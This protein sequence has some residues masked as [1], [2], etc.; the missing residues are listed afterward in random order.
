MY[1]ELETEGTIHF[2]Y[3]LKPPQ[4]PVLEPEPLRELSAWRSVLRDGR[5]ADH[6][7][8]LVAEKLPSLNS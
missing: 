4:G 1:R 3:E 7:A 5:T 8:W 2:A 6:N